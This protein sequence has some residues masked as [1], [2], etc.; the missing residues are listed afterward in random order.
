[1][2]K[3]KQHNNKGHTKLLVSHTAKPCLSLSTQKMIFT[4]KM[5]VSAKLM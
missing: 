4:K 1:M 3:N 5:N 2:K